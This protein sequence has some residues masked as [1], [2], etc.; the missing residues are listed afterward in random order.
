[1]RNLPSAVYTCMPGKGYNY[2]FYPACSLSASWSLSLDFNHTSS[3][4]EA[5][6]SL[7][8]YRWCLLNE[9]TRRAVTGRLRLICAVTH[10]SCLS[11]RVRVCVMT[12][13]AAGAG[14]RF[15][16]HKHEPM[17]PITPRRYVC[18]P[19]GVKSK[20][21]PEGETGTCVRGAYHPSGRR[22]RNIHFT[23][24][25]ISVVK[26]ARLLK[27]CCLNNKWISW[28][29]SNAPRAT[30]E[31]TSSILFQ[32][33]DW[34]SLWL[35]DLMRRTGRLLF[36]FHEFFLRV[37]QFHVNIEHREVF[38]VFTIPWEECKTYIGFLFLWIKRPHSY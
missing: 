30:L 16:N 15:I 14:A 27:L 7:F 24:S 11:V 35:T 32:G 3:S 36:S 21:R 37:N 26:T 28:W 20:E 13:R 23:P 5:A 31:A 38:L 12:F 29:E 25:N 4:A 19:G 1:M 33:N 6:V 8:P 2:V 22:G 10:R 34:N 17:D 9:I 18:L